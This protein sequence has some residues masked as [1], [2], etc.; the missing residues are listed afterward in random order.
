MT[1]S[2]LLL[3]SFFQAP[4]VP[5]PPPA[6]ELT[7]EVR[8]AL[9]RLDAEM[10]AAVKE[11]ERSPCPPGVETTLRMISVGKADPKPLVRLQRLILGWPSWDAA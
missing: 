1:A 8:K 11:L 3:F 2:A 9:V 10:A 5:K 7:P 6:P 4:P